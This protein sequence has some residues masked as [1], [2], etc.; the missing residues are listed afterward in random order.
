SRSASVITQPHFPV[1]SANSVSPSSSTSSPEYSHHQSY[2]SLLSALPKPSPP[3]VKIEQSDDLRPVA[4]RMT[5]AMSTVPRHQ[6]TSHIPHNRTPSTPPPTTSTDTHLRWDPKHPTFS[7]SVKSTPYTS[8]APTDDLEEEEEEEYCDKDNN[9]VNDAF[10]SRS[11][12]PRSHDHGQTC[13]SDAMEFVSPQLRSSM[14]NNSLGRFS[15]GSTS[16]LI[17]DI[18]DNT[19]HNNTKSGLLPGAAVASSLSSSM[20]TEETSSKPPRRIISFEV[21]HCPVC[22]KGFKPS[23]NQNCNLRRHLKNVHTLSPTIHP[24]K[25]KWDSLPAGRVKDD[26]DR[27]ER[28]RNSKRLWARKFR[29]R[30][31]VEEAAE[32]L[33]MLNQAW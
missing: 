20:S 15:K 9:L 1:A 19:D 11:P 30:Q 18:P 33:T 21:L 16:P 3:V 29:L 23:K 4:T 32:V 26:K 10:M 27:K 22:N 24:R 25:C 28:T 12:S 6:Y 5:R 31:R 8:P 17:S 2:Q 14:D 13:E 7:R